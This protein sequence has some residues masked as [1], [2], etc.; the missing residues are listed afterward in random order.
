MTPPATHKVSRAAIGQRVEII[1]VSFPR[2]GDRIGRHGV[3]ARAIASRNVYKIALD[4]GDWWEALPANVAFIA[5][6]PVAIRCTEC[7]AEWRNDEDLPQIVA[8]DG[9]IVKGCPHCGTDDYLVDIPSG[10]AG[11]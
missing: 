5:P 6:V 1:A 4:G 9:E 10:P 3:I 8:P 11:A 7:G 2:Y